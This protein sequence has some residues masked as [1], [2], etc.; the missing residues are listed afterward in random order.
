MAGNIM[1]ATQ[2]H[3][4]RRF[5]RADVL[6]VR[7][8]RMEAATFGRIHRAWHIPLKDDPFRLVIGIRDR[9]SGKEGLGVGMLGTEE[10]FLRFR[11]LHDFPKVHHGYPIGDVLHHGKIVGHEKVSE[12]ELV[13][14]I[15]EEVE[16]LGLDGDV[17]GG[18]GLVAHDEL[19]V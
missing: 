14:K 9:Y 2:I 12:A 5:L 17:Q 1:Q 3:K 18:D 8:A 15:L 4:L 19:G 10:N 13:L 7:A 11:E 6:G 16:D